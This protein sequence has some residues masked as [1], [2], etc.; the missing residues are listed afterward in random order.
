MWAGLLKG[1][2][3]VIEVVGLAAS[4]PAIERRRGF[5]DGLSKYPWCADLRA[6]AWGLGKAEI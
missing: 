5:Q 4:S 2:G 6:G 1:K 3:N